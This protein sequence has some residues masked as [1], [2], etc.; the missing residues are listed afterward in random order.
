MSPES[1]GAAVGGA[2]GG[3][4]GFINSALNRA[5]QKEMAQKAVRWRVHDLKAAG[6]NPVLAAQGALGGFLGGSGSGAPATDFGLGASAKANVA[7]RQVRLGEEKVEAE[8]E[9]IRAQTAKMI[10]DATNMSE[11]TRTEQLTQN[12]LGLQFQASAQ[13]IAKTNKWLEYAERYPA[14]YRRKMFGTPITYWTGSARD[15]AE[16]I[17]LPEGDNAVP[18]S[19]LYDGSRLQ[20]II[21]S[22][23]R[24][25]PE[26]NLKGNWRSSFTGE[27]APGTDK[28]R[29]KR[30]R[31]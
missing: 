14:A 2:V 9:G 4:V 15:D 13:E 8:V 22:L 23:S 24:W 17:F 20:G 3:G 5:H 11:K 19:D 12:L 29:R 10:A 6:L 27:R 1:F 31:R 30:S 16:R 26:T 28:P 7:A 18:I 25:K 21:D